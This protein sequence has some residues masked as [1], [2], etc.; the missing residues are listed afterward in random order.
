MSK[1]MIYKRIHTWNCAKKI[2]DGSRA[3]YDIH[4]EALYCTACFKETLSIKKPQTN[5]K[6]ARPY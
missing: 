1:I 6:D 5:L 4:S 3:Q 2:D